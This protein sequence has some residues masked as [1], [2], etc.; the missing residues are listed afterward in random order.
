MTLGELQPEDGSYTVEVSLEGGSGRATIE[1]PTELSVEDGQAMAEITWSSN[2]YDYMVV[3]GEKYLPVSREEHSVFEIPVEVF[4]EGIDVIG[5][6]TA[7]S[8]PHEVEY[9]LT[10]ASDSIQG[11]NG[12]STGGAGS[13]MAAAGIVII[14]VA[15]AIAATVMR[16]KRNTKA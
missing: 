6:T 12:G 15:A 4:D 7:M 2:H 3:D 14:A 13:T 10:F 5:D 8:T 16:K 9:T 11:E 1:S